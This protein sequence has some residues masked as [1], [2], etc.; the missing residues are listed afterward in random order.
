MSCLGQHGAVFGTLLGMGGVTVAPPFRW[1]VIER[2]ILN[3]SDLAE[4]FLAIQEI[5][6]RRYPGPHKALWCGSAW[7]K[8]DL[9]R[10]ADYAP[11]D[12]LE[13]I[14]RENEGLI[15]SQGAS[16]GN[17]SDE[18]FKNH[19]FP[20]FNKRRL[21]HRGDRLQL[22]NRLF[23]NEALFILRANDDRA[24]LVGEYLFCPLLDRALSGLPP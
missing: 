10:E 9:P 6:F 7:N 13:Y 21:V 5:G 3:Q 16:A 20:I 19:M 8:H 15:A 17:A 14:D 24:S 2:T 11:W 1:N 23:V 12:M 22:A 18:A 4:R